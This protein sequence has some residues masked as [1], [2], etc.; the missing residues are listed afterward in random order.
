MADGIT[1]PIN[2]TGR[3]FRVGHDSGDTFDEGDDFDGITVTIEIRNP[4]EAREVLSAL[5]ATQS[6]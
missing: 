1:L 3:R 4:E 5:F 6:T 2:M